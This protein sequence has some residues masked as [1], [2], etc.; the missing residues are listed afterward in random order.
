MRRLCLAL[1]TLGLVALS[2]VVNPQPAVACDCTGIS[3]RRALEQSDAVFLGSVIR[4]DELGNGDTRRADIRFRVSRVF[5]GTV[6]EEQVVASAPDRAACGL[7]PQ[8]GSTW[9]IF[10]VDSVE[11]RGRDALYR[12]RTTVCSGNLPRDAAPS[13]L[14]RGADPR[15]GASDREERVTGIDA[16]LTRGLIIAGL[17]GLGLVALIGV[18]LIY[19]WR[20]GRR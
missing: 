10:A 3:T 8:P 13:L 16:Q 19:L 4:V 15:P 7:T 18:G 17:V 14:G 6:Y 1:L 12:L 11:G 20:P 2:F 5:K 9:V